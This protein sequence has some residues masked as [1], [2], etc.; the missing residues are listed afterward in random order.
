[1]DRYHVQSNNYWSSTEYDS[2][3]AWNVNMN[4][5]NVNNN[6]KDNNNYVWPVRSDNDSL[7]LFSFENIYKQYLKCRKN[8][9]NTVNALRFEINCEENLFDLKRQLDT[10]SYYPSRSVC[11]MAVKPKLREIFAADLKDRIVHHILVDYLEKIF[12]PKFIFDSYACRK[13]K[14]IHAGVTRLRSFVRKATK[15]GSRNAFYMQL[16]IKNYFMSIDK[17]ILFDLIA[18][19]V[20]DE[21]VLNLASKLIFHDCTNNYVLKG[22]RDYLKKIASQKSLFFT[23]GKKGLPIGN[24]TSQFFANVYLNELDQFVKHRLKCRYYLRYCDD[25]VMLS[26]SREALLKW[27]DEITVFLAERLGLSLNENRQ[28]LQPVTN[29]INF[30]GYIVRK[31]YLLVRRRVVNNLREKLSYFEKRLVTDDKPPYVRVM[32]DYELL[33]KLRATLASYFGH[34]RWANTF[35]LKKSLLERYGFLNWFF[36]IEGW[37]IIPKYKMPVKIPTLKLQYRYFKGKFP[38]DVIFFRKGKYY[39]FFGDDTDTALKLGLK[40]M[41]RHSDRNTKYGF[42]IWLEKSFSERIKQLGRSLTV[43]TEGGR[44]LTG[45]KERFPKYRLVAQL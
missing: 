16:D 12:E 18:A 20:T 9:R 33:E 5:G 1:M 40:K 44:Y 6:N 27:K 8:K 13:D 23:G 21:R 28:R 4:N 3:N 30:L 14:G 22:D 41:N 25:F 38:E 42:P 15:N 26:D 31:D 45:I 17:K 24:L 39:E 19:K 36:T 7:R 2:N 37:K 34:F 10:G 35:R 32:Y 43:I 29:G 11:F